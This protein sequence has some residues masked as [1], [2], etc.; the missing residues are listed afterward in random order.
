MNPAIT[1]PALVLAGVAV[2]RHDPATGTVWRLQVD[3]FEV[4][5]QGRIGL[6]GRSGSGKTTLLE[7]LGLLIWPA[8]VGRFDLWD[9]RGR[10]PVALQPAIRDRRADLLAAVRARSIGFVLQ[11]SGLLPYLT[12]A[13]NAALA[14]DLAGVDRRDFARSLPRFARLLGLSDLVDRKP[15]LLSGGQRQRAAVLRALVTGARL[16]IADEPTAALDPE[17]SEQVLQT[18]TEAATASGAALIVA[19]H[20]AP[21]LR[22]HGFA[23]TEITGETDASGTTARLQAEAA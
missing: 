20:N 1:W 11:D 2:T 21:L 5:P 17:T 3:H 23:I 16:L 10:A 15:A 19:S 14:A 8:E 9:G 22:R 4:P 12:V 13:E 18:I 6:I 7:V